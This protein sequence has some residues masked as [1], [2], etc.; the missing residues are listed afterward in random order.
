MLRKTSAQRA[1]PLSLTIRPLDPFSEASGVGWRMRTTPANERK[2]KIHILFLLLDTEHDDTHRSPTHTHT[3]THETC[4]NCPCEQLHRDIIALTAGE[5]SA[6]THIWSLKLSEK[7]FKRATCGRCA[8]RWQR[9]SGD[10]SLI[11][12]ICFVGGGSGVEISVSKHSTII[13]GIQSHAAASFL[14]NIALWC[15]QPVLK[16]SHIDYIT[17]INTLFT[18]RATEPHT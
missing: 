9:D 4:R 12:Q 14:C 5:S 6:A 15:A 1:A 16:V 18:F 2:I 7:T 11:L 17:P 13:S 8:E 3:H 10:L